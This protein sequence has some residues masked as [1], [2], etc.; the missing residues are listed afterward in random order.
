MHVYED[1]ISVCAMLLIHCVYVVA[2]GIWGWGR[3]GVVVRRSL[4]GAE[5]MAVL[6]RGEGGVCEY[7]KYINMT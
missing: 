3:G 7:S 1:L 4:S 5:V 2:S 6:G